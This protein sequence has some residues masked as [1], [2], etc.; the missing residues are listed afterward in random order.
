MV[1][2]ILH[3]QQSLFTHGWFQLAL[4]YRHHAPAHPFQFFFIALITGLVAFNFLLPELAVGMWDMPVHLMPVPETPVHEYRHTVFAQH[5]VRRARQ[6]AHVLP[7]AVAPA[8]KVTTHDEFRLRVLAADFRHDG[9]AFLF[10]P[11]VHD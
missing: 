2:P 10:I 8:P 4:P 3:L 1:D 11:D 5:D 7:I 6:P 9:G